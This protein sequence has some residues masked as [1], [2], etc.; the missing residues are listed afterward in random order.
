MDAFTSGLEFSRYDSKSSRQSEIIQDYFYLVQQNQGFPGGSEGKESTCQFRRRKRCSF[1]PW[2][3]KIPWRRAWQPTPV[4][5][6]GK[7]HGQRSLAGYSPWSHSVWHN[8][9]H[10]HIAEPRV[11]KCSCHCPMVVQAL[12]AA[13]CSASPVV[14]TTICKMFTPTFSGAGS[15][16]LFSLV[17][18]VWFWNSSDSYVCSLISILPTNSLS[19]WVSEWKSFS[20]VQLFV[21]PWTIQS[22][23]FSRPEYSSS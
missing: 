8:W 11:W 4:F 9:E 10:T 22:K 15:Y 1:N 23:E 13:V 19:F 3:G 12:V 14:P 20:C 21:T 6:P 16:A 17:S 18:Q 7:S 2:V 5:L